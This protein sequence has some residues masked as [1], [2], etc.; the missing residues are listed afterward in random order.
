V[1]GQTTFGTI[2]GTITDSSGAVMP[3]AAVKATNEGTGVERTVKTTATG[4]YV[5]PN[6]N[7]GT[8][9]V[10]IAKAGFQAYEKSGIHLNA[11]EI[12]N[13]DAKLPVATTDTSVEVVASAAEI[14]TQTPTVSNV[15]PA[16]QLEQLPVITR[17]KGD[18]ALY[19]YE[20]YNN[21]IG[22]SPFFV[23]NGSRYIDT[24]PTVDGITAMSFQTGVG[25]ST[26]QTGVE[27]T[28]EVSVQ[29]AG[30]PA[31]FGRPVQM[32]MISKGGTNQFR[33]SV[34]EDYNGNDLNARDFFAASA[35]FR[36]YND[37]GASLGGPIK[38]NKTFFFGDYEASRE[39][40]A[41]IDT[42]NVPL[43][44]WRTGDFS[45]LGNTIVNPLTGQPFPG[46]AIPASM[47]NPVSQKVQNLYF[48][49]PNYGPPTL[50]AGNYRALFHPGNN[51]VT[52]FDKFDTRFD[53]YFSSRDTLFGRFSYN[54]MPINAFVA[55][56]IPP[57]SF[58]T[59]L[60]KANSAVVNWTHAFSPT[61]LNVARFG[62]TRDNNQIKNPV[63][64]SQILQ[65]VGIQGV[66]TAGIPTYPSFS[67]TGLTSPYVVPNFGGI[68]T[69][70]QWTDSLSWIHGSHSMKFGFDAIRDRDESFTYSGSVYGSYN[71]TGGFTG[72][73]Y[74]D[75]LLGLPQT[76][77]LTAPTPIPHQFGTWWAAYAQDQF[78]VTPNLTLNYGLRWE[79]QGPYS[80]NRGLLTSFDP[81]TGALVVADQGIH[82]INPL[83]PKNIP[84]ETATQA[85]YP[86][87]LLASHHAYFYPRVGFAY[88]PFSSN[89]MA[90]RGGYGI[91]GLTTYGSAALSL[92]GGPFAGSQSFT[93]KI[94]N[95][96][97]LFSFPNPFLTSGQ[98]PAQSVTGIDPNLRIGYMQQW[99]IGVERELAGFALGATYV[100][101][102]TVN[103]PYSRNLN[104][105]RPSLQPF[106]SSELV[107]PA[108]ISVNWVQNGGTERYN[109][110][111]LH[112]QRT[113]GKNLFVNAGF[114]W[115][116][117]LTDDQ[118]T[119][120]F[121]GARIQDAY[122]RAAEYGPNGYVR[123]RRFF[124]NVVYTL[125][126]GEGQRFL[127]NISKPIDLVLGG[128]RMAW[129]VI[130]EAGPYY[131]PSFSG[132]DPSN[133]N[134]IGGRPDRIG[135]TSFAIPGCLASNP[136]CSNP[137]NIG[138]FG[139]AGVNTLQAQGFTDFDLSLMK[140]F[141][142]TERFV[143]QF[144]AT[145]TD[146]FN[147]PNFGVPASN[148][149]SPGTYGIVTST[150]SELLGQNARQLDLM[151]RLQF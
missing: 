113:Y 4:V 50:Q 55:P 52:V 33:G 139:N 115:A 117:D 56:V 100:G 129:N 149:S 16:A 145:A 151:L 10:R 126:V 54:R 128:W 17:Q 80:D 61:L 107:Y 14:N 122:N 110:L 63:I 132:F 11:T 124:A 119:Q 85:G 94:V 73:A 75:F 5:V 130:A 64:G 121:T 82:S 36:V 138:R 31:E 69:D 134:N 48:L 12:L 43:L 27:A 140:D 118:D 93:N 59:S 45:A 84:I 13:V 79:A 70:F 106:S 1:N 47:I 137:A 53:H 146:V 38:K 42:L 28:G 76:T 71:F 95:G 97:P 86:S 20:T 51:G 3:D 90:I 144:R 9:R 104:Q 141:R 89:K 60:R 40:T 142:V 6:L 96:A 68:G 99:T 135:P 24:Q 37:F 15:T 18:Q 58:R 87:S 39:S 62:Y 147:H 44:A 74:A 26:V 30:A 29:L 83:Y 7:A 92:T 57:F 143:L 114:T 34:F 66:A 98:T 21:G 72:S 81:K 91:Y 8:Y 150:F 120:G 19:G 105:P 88:R 22:H 109:A 41:V 112:A 49:N 127:G 46:N 23:A 101:T 123:P 67:V 108:Y 131:T 125:P 111:Q 148:I 116:K 133:T 103:M 32:T 77:G 25:G 35:P 136:I 2:T 102:H 65:Q 78:K